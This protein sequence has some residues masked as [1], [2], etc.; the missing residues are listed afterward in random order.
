MNDRDAHSQLVRWVKSVTGLTTIKSHQSGDMPALPY[1]MV[2]M[3]S[4]REVRAHEQTIEYEDQGAEVKASPVIEVEWMFSVHSYGD[5]PTDN[6]R[7]IRSAMKLSQ[8]MEP[9][10][11][12]LI[13]H[14][15]SQIRN[16]PDWINNG[17]QPRAQMDVFVRGLTR[18]GFLIDVIEQTQF[19][20][21]RV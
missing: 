17:W 2:N 13:V 20:F 18:D 4:T 3:T 10:F 15:V 16:V 11:P 21:E 5:H 14:S 19:T 8:V 12:S 1:N 6:L 9:M 7:G